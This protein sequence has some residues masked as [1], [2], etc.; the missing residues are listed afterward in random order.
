MVSPSTQQPPGN[1]TNDGLSAASIP[2]RSGRKPFWRFFQVF[3]GKSETMSSQKVPFPA[4][5][6][7]RRALRVGGARLSV[8]NDRSS[9]LRQPGRCSAWHS[10]GPS[11]LTSV[12]VNGP[13]NTVAGTSLQRQAV[14]PRPASP[15]CPSSP[16]L[17]I[18]APVRARLV[19]RDLE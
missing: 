16:S 12:T 11:L 19:D 1:R 8:N 13:S 5:E 3:L 15:P 17:M 4:S 14:N 2:A 6:I 10:N 9:S 7:T 18:P